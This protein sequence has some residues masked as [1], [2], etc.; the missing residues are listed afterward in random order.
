MVADVRNF[1][2][3][4]KINV[5]VEAYDGQWS[6]LVFCD[7]NDKPLTLFELQRDCWLKFKTMSQEKLINFIESL[8]KNISQNLQ[9]WTST[10]MIPPESKRITNIQVNLKWHTEQSRDPLHMQH[11][12][13]FIELES[14]CNEHN[15]EGGLSMVTFPD[16]NKRPDAWQVHILEP[17]LLHLLELK[18][19]SG[20]QTYYNHQESDSKSDTHDQ[21]ESVEDF[22]ADDWPDE[23]D[24][25]PNLTGCDRDDK[26]FVLLSSHSAITTEIIFLLL[27]GKRGD[28]WISLD[29][30]VNEVLS[31]SESIFKQLTAYEI[32]DILPVLQ[33]YSSKKCHLFIHPKMKKLKKSNFLGHILGHYHHYSAYN[34]WAV[35]TLAV[36]TILSVLT[37]L[38]WTTS[39]IPLA[40]KISVIYI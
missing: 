36:E 32:D 2:H 3:Q 9:E 23:G 24:T 7:H 18:K 35:S 33:W 30:Q 19:F 38:S 10:S 40:A 22:L 4:Q 25:S 29:A 27:C 37:T 1:L 15:C 8:S 20:K 34:Q 31:S 16:V 17:N 11:C 39:G 12:K 13:S 26:K 21:M 14:Y 6:S 28:K 5:L